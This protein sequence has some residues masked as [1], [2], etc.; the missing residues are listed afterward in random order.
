MLALV[1]ADRVQLETNRLTPEVVAGEA[2]IRVQQA[3]ICATDLE[4]VK[5]YMGFQGVLGHEFVGVIEHADEQPQL[6][7]RRVVGEINAACRVCET[8]RAGR[9]THCPHRTTLGIDRRDGAFADY[10]CLPYENLHVLPESLTDD[11][12]VFVEPLAAA[13]Q[14]LQQAS[15]TPSDHVVVLGD[16]KLGLLCAQVLQLT[17]CHLDVCGHH[18]DKLTILEKRGINATTSRDKISCDADVVVE[19]TGTSRGFATACQLVRPR[20][21]IVLKSTYRGEVMVNTTSLVVNEVTLVGSR[22]GPFE[23]AIRLLEQQLI[24]VTPLIHSHYP[25]DQALTA[26]DRA[27]TKGTLKVMLTMT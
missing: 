5:G 6:R 21:T 20:G 11:Q 2:L 24:D 13:C 1:L 25:I 22:C 19:A 27:S 10:L 7:G 23:P 8:C 9:P 14:I 18:P 3:G 16:G 17:G 15:I 26:L 12:A 4:L